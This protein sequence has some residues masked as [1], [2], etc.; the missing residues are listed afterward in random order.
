MR[1]TLRSIGEA[2][3]AL[4]EF[5]LEIVAAP[6]FDGDAL[7]ILRRKKQLRVMRFDESLPDELAHELRLRSALGG[8]LAED[9][10]PGA[11]AE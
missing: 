4:Q 2:A 6:D 5:F 9:D 1:P 8:V 10:D 7:E 11:Q 3:L